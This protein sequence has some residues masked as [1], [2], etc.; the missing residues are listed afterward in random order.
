MSMRKLAMLRGLGPASIQDLAVGLVTKDL[1]LIN[2]VMRYKGLP[3]L[4][5]LEE[6]RMILGSPEELGL[7]AHRLAILR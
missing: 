2:R 6:A 3:P 1:A 5:S 7:L 4:E